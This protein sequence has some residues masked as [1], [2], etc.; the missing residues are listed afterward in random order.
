[1]VEENKGFLEDEKSVL[2]DVRKL[3]K[4]HNLDKLSDTRT[5]TELKSETY[6]DKIYSVFRTRNKLRK[7]LGEKVKER[8]L[9]DEIGRKELIQDYIKNP[10][11][12]W[13]ILRREIPEFQQIKL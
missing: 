13:N 8:K 11:K 4:E 3:L 5:L 9:A 12:Y 10:V 2:E 7:A 1:M 6:V